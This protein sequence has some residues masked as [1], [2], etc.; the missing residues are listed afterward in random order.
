MARRRRPCSAA[1]KSR[2]SGSCGTIG[3]RSA[4]PPNQA[5]RGH[6]VARVHVHRRHL[7]ASACAPPARCREAKKRGSSAAPGIW[8]AELRAELAE[9]G[10]DVDAD[11]L[12]HA[13]AH[14]RHGAAAA[15][16]AGSAPARAAR[17]CARSGRAAARACVPVQLVLDLLEVGADAVA[18]ACEPGRASSLRRATVARRAAARGRWGRCVRAG[19]VMRLG[20][21]AVWRRAS[22]NT[23]A[24]A[25]ATLSDRA[26]GLQRDPHPEIGGRVDVGRHAGAFAAEQQDVVGPESRP[27]GKRSAP[28]GG[29]QDQ[30]AGR[31]VRGGKRPRRRAG[32]SV[33]Q[34]VIV[35]GG[36]ADALVVDRKAAGLD[37][38]ERHAQAGGQADEGPEILRDIGLD[39]G[40][41]A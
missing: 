11:L 12:E 16:L 19:C 38:V 37:D 33:R 2:V 5:L 30:P 31:P 23:I 29:Q 17:P 15:I 10:R 14:E 27:R 40:P 4:P 3:V 34:V 20:N 1:W 36:P 24:A 7:A 28:G 18:Q 39:T 13:A 32:R 41:G 26:P 8:L 9:H 6:D 22:L 21:P 35:H 25:R